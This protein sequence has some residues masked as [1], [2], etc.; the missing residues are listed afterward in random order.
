[1]DKLDKALTARFGPGERFQSG[2]V[3]YY[4]CGNDP[5]TRGVA[6]YR[7]GFYEAKKDSA[8]GNPYRGSQQAA[9]EAGHTYPSRE[10]TQFCRG[11]LAGSGLPHV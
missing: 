11:Y 4:N 8:P 2:I 6:A 10:W 1:M 9:I 5:I 7:K 3:V